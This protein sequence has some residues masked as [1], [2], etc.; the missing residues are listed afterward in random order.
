[1]TH[2]RCVV[3]I[4][5]SLTGFAMVALYPDGVLVQS[6]HTTKSTKTL[7]GRVE[8]LGVLASAAENFVKEHLPSLCL[9]EGYAHA[10]KWKAAAIGELGG[11]V[12][13]RI[14]GLAD[15]TVEVPPTM[16]KKF[17]TGK[18]NAGK[19]DVVQKVGKKFN[20]VFKTDNMADALGLAWLG[21]A[22]VGFCE[23]TNA[24]QREIVKL[25]SKMRE[26]ETD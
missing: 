13:T 22:V 26:Q 21:G 14:V 4:D 12:R 8:R 5:P 24:P 7:S 3:G 11:V 23:T 19:L 25:V 6:E 2:S 1:M 17:A 15:V 16:L 18:G 10:A 9:I 20:V